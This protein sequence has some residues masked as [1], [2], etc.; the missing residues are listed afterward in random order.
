MLLRIAVVDGQGGSIG[1]AIIKRIRQTLGDGVEVWALGTNAVATSRMLKAGANRGAA[2]EGAV[3]HSVN[4]ADVVV[5]SISILIGNSFMGELTEAMAGA[6][7]NSG[8]IKLLL[9]LT[10]EPA[11]V[12]GSASEPLP[13]QMEK[14]IDVFLTPLARAKSGEACGGPP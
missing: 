6:I 14:L 7:S 1:S 10:Q 3:R 2:G 5:G 13:H 9:P 11:H 12:I 8:A 4:R